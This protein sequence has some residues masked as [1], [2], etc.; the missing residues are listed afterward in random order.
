MFPEEPS[1]LTVSLLLVQLRLRE[2]HIEGD[3]EGTS[4]VVVV[5]V[6][7]A[8]AFLPHPSS[9]LGDLVSDDV[10]LPRS[11]QQILKN[12]HHLHVALYQH[13]G[14]KNPKTLNF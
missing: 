10:D 11:T 6:G 4:D 8:L 9:G 13:E 3:D 2:L 5:K 1:P 7:Q 14:G 12:R